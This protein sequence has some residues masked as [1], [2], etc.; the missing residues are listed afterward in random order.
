[1]AE[2][3]F[4]A[5]M[6]LDPVVGVFVTLRSSE[7]MEKIFNYFTMSK[8]LFDELLNRLSPLLCKQVCGQETTEVVSRPSLHS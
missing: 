7:V 8:E 1:M 2:S 5:L 6:L 4:I 3:G